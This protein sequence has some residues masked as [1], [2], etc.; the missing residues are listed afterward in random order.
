MTTSSASSTP[1]YEPHE[2][3]PRFEAL[4]LGLQS[5]LL[6][7]A[8]IA[9]FPIV[10]FN[11][12]GGSATEVAWAVFAMSVAN[13]GVTILQA[14]RV[15]PMGAG[16]LVIPYPSPTAIPFCIWEPR[17]I[18]PNR[19]TPEPGTPSVIALPPDSNRL[20]KDSRSGAPGNLQAMPTIAIG[21]R[22]R[23]SP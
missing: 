8:P 6:V 21:S 13:G 23:E 5:A 2:S 14:F 7:V 4:G 16:L 17:K 11:A 9:L 10:L 20:Q 18:S 3:P 15:G 1:Q 22:T 19:P 12:V